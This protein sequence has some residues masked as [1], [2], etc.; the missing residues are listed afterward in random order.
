[1]SVS[2]MSDCVDLGKLGTERV[3]GEED[4]KVT[5]AVSEESMGEVW[6]AFDLEYLQHP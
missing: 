4:T 6:L 1:M 3:V 2:R 5:L